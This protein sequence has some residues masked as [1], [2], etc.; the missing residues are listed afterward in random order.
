MPAH[1]APTREAMSLFDDLVRHVR[2]CR[3]AA[4]P[5]RR[6]PFLLG[7]G[8]VGY[9]LA[10]DAE[11]LCPHGARM[12]GSGVSLPVEALHG[13]S[14]AL[15]QAGRFR[16][17]D[18]EF[19]VRSDEGGVVVAQ[20]D[21]GALPLFGITAWGAHLNGL[22]RKGDGWHLW[23]GRRADDRPLDPGKL[24]N[25]A[26]GGVPA[27]LSPEQTLVKEAEEEAGLPASL[28]G[29]P[30]RVETIR[31]ALER[32]EGLR[33]DCVV[34]FD[35]VLPP[36][37]VPVPQDN[38]IAGFELW[39]MADVLHRVRQTDDFKFNVNL[40]LIGLFLRLG[41]VAGGE[42]ERLRAELDPLAG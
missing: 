13:A 8:R 1:S 16:W 22:V 35:L 6:L 12:D 18:E 14:A 25:L 36:S 39:P 26:A 4:I 38:E 20:L 15:A 19:D 7:Q 41:L 31:Y 29:K 9:V 30:Q 11:F 27:G 10:E 21:R 40:V 28:L 32:P 33:R 37:F 5:G 34:C 42:A 24:D 2:A 17:R 3:S 23:I